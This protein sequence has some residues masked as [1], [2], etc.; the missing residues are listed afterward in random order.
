[1]KNVLAQLLKLI[2]RQLAADVSVLN[3]HMARAADTLIHKKVYRPLRGEN[4]RG[5]LLQ[6][7]M[8]GLDDG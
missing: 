6:Q 1:M 3:P 5:I 2:Q 8:M 4:F 7:A